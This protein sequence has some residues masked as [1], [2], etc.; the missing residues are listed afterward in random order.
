M[1]HYNSSA[2]TSSSSINILPS[3]STFDR[4]GKKRD[5]DSRADH[6]TYRGVRMRAWGKWVSEIREPKKKSRIWLGTYRTAEMAA[7]AHDVAARAIKGESAYLNFPELAGDLPLP[8]SS[9]P[10]DIQAAAAAFANSICLQLNVTEE[11]IQANYI[12]TSHFSDTSNESSNS[13]SINCEDNYDS[14][15]FDLPDLSVVSGDW[16]NDKYRLDYK[17]SW[18]LTPGADIEFCLDEPFHW[19]CD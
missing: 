14:S 19:K 7:R 4:K 5:R 13:V 18:Q 1:E 17:S 15:V 12:P 6:T 9:F 16:N 10:K 2:S 11:P 8:K 3:P